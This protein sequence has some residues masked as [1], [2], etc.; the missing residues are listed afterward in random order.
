MTF[1][2]RVRLENAASFCSY[3][4]GSS[5][6]KLVHDL[7]YRGH[8]AIGEE[9]GKGYGHELIKTPFNDSDLIVP[10][11]LNKRKLRQ[12]GY[13]QSECIARGLSRSME[14]AIITTAV[15]KVRNSSTQTKKSRYDRWLNV[16]D[17]FRVVDPEILNGKHI[18]LVDD[19]LTTGATIEACASEIL[20]VPG[21]RVSVVTL[22]VVLK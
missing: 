4:P 10:V 22:G 18:L 12:R 20:K 11:P 17:T 2:G 15:I 3:Q 19:V 21:T 8:Q 1:W 9:L 5:F 6:R 13:N 7:K 16:E 14:K